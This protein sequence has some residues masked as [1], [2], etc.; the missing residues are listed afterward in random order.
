MPSI[1][2]IDTLLWMVRHNILYNKPNLISYQWPKS[3]KN[4][5][6]KRGKFKLTILYSIRKTS[7]VSLNFLALQDLIQVIGETLSV[8]K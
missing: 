2:L 4:I 5:I 3:F 1:Q 6:D 8:L 7:F